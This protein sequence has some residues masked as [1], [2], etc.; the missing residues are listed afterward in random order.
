M[1]ASQILLN[2]SHYDATTNSFKYRFPY[3][4]TF[5]KNSKIALTSCNF[6]NSFFNI[7]SALGNNQIKIDFPS[8]ASWLS[9]SYTVPDGFY[10]TSGMNY[11]LQ[12]MAIDNKLFTITSTG[13][14]VYYWNLVISETEYKNAI[15]FYSV[16]TDAVPIS[17]A[18]WTAPTTLQRQAK[19]YW[20]KVAP[21]YGWI[22]D[23]TLTNY[24]GG[25][26]QDSQI[27]TSA[28]VAQVNPFNT[29]ILTCSLVRALG[30]SN[31]SNFLFS[32]PLDKS[33]GSM[34]TSPNIEP[35]YNSIIPGTHSEMEIILYNN[36]LQPLFLLDTNISI[37]LSI[38]KH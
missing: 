19:I 33:F 4:Q 23:S 6:Y 14:Y 34:I 11:L 15:T 32:Q 8:G 31:P 30:L 13:K 37:M 16:P 2:S 20:G 26:V 35:L 9:F 1:S 36:T 28:I 5:N 38:I 12:K 25:G 27:V 24:I 22:S 10:S 21:L 18:T 7:S 17:G 29:V 3:Q